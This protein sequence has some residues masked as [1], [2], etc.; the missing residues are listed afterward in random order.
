MYGQAKAVGRE[1]NEARGHVKRLQ[2]ELEDAQRTEARRVAAE[3]AEEE[4]RRAEGGG[5]EAE[6][7]SGGEGGA[8]GF[9]PTPIH[10]E[11]SRHKQ[12]YQTGFDRL[13]DM[14][15]RI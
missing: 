1:V 14:K 13:R 3:V 9:D 2:G 8:S 5:G 12:T 6:A 15:R 4:V 7:G 11:M 10:A